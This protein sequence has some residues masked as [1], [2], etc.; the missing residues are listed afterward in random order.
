MS[1]LSEMS[2]LTID[3]DRGWLGCKDFLKDGLRAVISLGLAIGIDLELKSF[4]VGVMAF[5]LGFLL[6]I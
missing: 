3:L 1:A 5:L 2:P 6:N 4:L